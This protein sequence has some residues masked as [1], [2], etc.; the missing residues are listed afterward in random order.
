MVLVRFF[1]LPVW[2]R[3]YGCRARRKERGV[4]RQL[5][6]QAELLPVVLAQELWGD[7]FR[8]RRVLIFVDNDAARH[9]L[10]KGASPSGP[11]AL[12]VDAF[13]T[14]EAELEAFSWVERVPS[15][16]NPADAPSRLQFSGLVALG[17][18]VR[19]TGEVLRLGSVS[20]F[21]VG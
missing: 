1:S 11:S 9:A 5:V 16:S 20:R 12:M 6:G 19:E 17:A 13:W 7:R 3:L 18:R 15:P 2:F 21:T 14:R 8:G 10:I 4:R